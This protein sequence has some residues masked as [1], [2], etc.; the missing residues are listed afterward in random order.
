MPAFIAREGDNFVF[1]PFPD[2]DYT[3]AGIYYAKLTALSTSNETNW[4]TTNAA[5]LLL[6]GALAASAGY[7]GNDGRV[8]LWERMY[9]SARQGVVDQEEREKFSQGMSLAVGLS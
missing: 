7:I 3:L 4:F 5:D 8:E 6:Y 9:E 2:S 1:G